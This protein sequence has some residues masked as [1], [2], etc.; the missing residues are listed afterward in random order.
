MSGIEAPAPPGW[1]DVLA[2]GPTGLEAPHPK[3]FKGRACRT[4]DPHSTSLRAGSRLPR[5]SFG[6]WWRWQTSCAFLCGKVHAQPCSVP[7]DRKSGYA[8]SKNIPRNGPGN[9][10]SL[11]FDGMTKGRLVL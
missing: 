11:G 9:C 6:T 3:T 8:P 10:R 2:V 1:A 5:I 7:R 4:A